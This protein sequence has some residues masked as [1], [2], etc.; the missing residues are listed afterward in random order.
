MSKPVMRIIGIPMDLGQKRRGV[1]MGPSAIRYAGLQ[2]K[3]AALGFTTHDCG[4]L[5]VPQAEQMETPYHGDKSTGRAHYLP[6]V[7][8]VCQQT[9]EYTRFCVKPADRVIFLGGDHSMSIGTISAMAQDDPIGVIWVDA[10]SDI[11][12][13]HTTPSG[14]IHGMPVAV[15]LGD[16][17]QPLV[18][19]GYGG[20]KLK[21]SQVAM[22]GL[23]DLDPPERERLS[24]GDIAAYTM[25]E[26]DEHGIGHIIAR[27]LE[28]FASFKDIHVSLDLD[29]LDPAIAPGVGTPVPGGLA[30]REA[31]LLME[32][33]ADSGKVRSLDIVETNP[34]LDH[35]NITAEVA[36]ALATSLFGKRIL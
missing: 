29:S 26:V 15:L 31:H 33:L 16:G 4:N 28:R 22:I 23:R 8:E 14:N 30:L 21:P 34:I 35:S 3:I 27:I 12:T 10:H 9:Y 11:N 20:P 1:D 25:R 7:A 24:Q 17:A 6:Q 18:N 2:E 32:I 13:P 36:V 19:I 5:T